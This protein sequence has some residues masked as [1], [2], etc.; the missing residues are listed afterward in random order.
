MTAAESQ[1]TGR[2]GPRPLVLHLTVAMATWMS[3]RGG[4]PLWRNGSLPW[5]G[6]LA[7]KAAEL[8][9]EIEQSAPADTAWD[10]LGVALE[11]E[12][13]HRLAALHDGLTIYRQ[14]S[15]RRDLAAPPVIWTAGTTRLLDFGA[16]GD[17]ARGA[18]LVV[19]SL[20]NRSTVLDLC[21]GQSLLRWLAGRGVRPLL[22][23]WDAPGIGE[24]RFGLTDYV[25]RLE[26]ALAV[27][28][29]LAG[30]PV[31]VVGYCM[32]GLLAL[33]LAARRP[34]DVARLALLATPWDFHADDAARR[35][36]GAV[37]TALAA[38]TPVITA[39]G[40]LPVDL[41]QVL[42]SLLDPMQVP[43]KFMRLSKLDPGS[44]K[45]VTF[46]ALEDWLN[47]GVAL[48]GPVAH[49]CM[50]GW[51]GGNVTGRGLWEIDGGR[52]DPAA[53]DQPTLALIPSGDRIVPPPT[54]AALAAKLP[55]GEAVSV[56]LGHIGM[57]VSARAERLVWPQLAHWL[58]GG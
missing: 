27:A 58:G 49:E 24:R 36:A 17:R 35:Q 16:V 10:A 2:L 23:D 21:E 42:F 22:V 33:A 13:R 31:P 48:A 38:W 14:H 32:G 5:S 18:V 50:G 29:N 34:D 44:A 20:I 53:I 28:N 54:A 46:V 51:Y 55:R 26:A 8:R 52:I 47:D 41:I 9:R 7:E 3:S 25:A 43:R 37:A 1:K 19:P 15:Y 56:P 4:L 40:E 12:S 45:A 11:R 30:G 39:L 6:P 57:V